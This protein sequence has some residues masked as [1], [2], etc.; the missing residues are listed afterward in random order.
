MRKQRG[1]PR[2]AEGAE[3][4]EQARHRRQLARLLAAAAVAFWGSGH[5]K[6]N[7]GLANACSL[8]NR[9]NIYP[10]NTAQQG[11][12]VV[13]RPLTCGSIRLTT[14]G[15][16][17][18]RTKLMVFVFAAGAMGVASSSGAMAQVC[19]PGYMFYG[20]VCQP[21][22][23]PGY[24][25]PVSGAVT[26]AGAGAAS[27]AATGSNVAGPVGGVVGGTLG[28]ATGIVSGTLSGTAGML[29]PSA[30]PVPPSCPPGYMNYNGNCYP[31]R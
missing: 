18:M 23:P 6:I 9:R 2:A 20:G 15:K 28:T 16:P 11:G 25:N 7:L 5:V 21:S 29:T 17:I 31:A 13:E 1:A 26:G 22:T 3:G 24:S 4:C 8:P 19:P 12:S 10:V 14:R 27:G 30:P